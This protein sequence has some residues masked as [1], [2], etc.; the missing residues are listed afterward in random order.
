[1]TDYSCNVMIQ[2]VVTA[3]VTVLGWS[4]ASYLKEKGKYLATK[5]DIAG[6]TRQIEAVKTEHAE[7]L[8]ALKSQLNAK[9][10]AHTVRFEKEFKALEEIWGKLLKLRNTAMKLRPP[11][12]SYANEE[13]TKDEEKKKRFN[14]YRE[15]FDAFWAVLY[16]NQPF[17]PPEIFSCLDDLLSTIWKE[18][19][20]FKNSID[21]GIHPTK[22]EVIAGWNEA[23][24]NIEL[25]IEKTNTVCA[26]IRRRIE[27]I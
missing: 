13:R 4:V 15:A 17:L 5:Q 7:K 24:D 23:Q 27:E 20:S 2:A 21:R 16:P 3:G 18:A 19:S 22:A 8:E 25:I 9:F 14:E 11:G 26:M 6:I 12:E 10:H 1:M